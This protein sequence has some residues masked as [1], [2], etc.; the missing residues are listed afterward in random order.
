MLVTTRITR[1]GAH[2]GLRTSEPLLWVR[3][4]GHVVSQIGWLRAQGLWPCLGAALLGG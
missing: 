1:Q 2:I 4:C 3:Q